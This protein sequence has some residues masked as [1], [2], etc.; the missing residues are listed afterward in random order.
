MISPEKSSKINADYVS[1]LG[2]IRTNSDICN[3]YYNNLF[4]LLEIEA[5][6]D[7]KKEK[8]KSDLAIAVIILGAIILIGSAIVSPYLFGQKAITR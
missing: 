4:D 6:K 1:K 7:Y 2:S 5:A 8:K 3:S